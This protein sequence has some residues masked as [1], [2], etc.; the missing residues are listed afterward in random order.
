MSL[1]F[2]LHTFAQAQDIRLFHIERNKNNSIVCYDLHVDDN[3]EINQQNPIDAYW[4]TPDK[5][6]SR[7]SLSLV[8][9]KLAYGLTI[10]KIEGDDISFKLKAYPERDIRV[11]YDSENRQANAYTYI[12]GAF[13]VLKKLYIHAS[14]PLY[15]SVEYIILEGY[16][17]ETGKEVSEMIINT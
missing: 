10:D 9:Y 16:D 12:N 6:N 5:D 15:K 17:P 11:I 8:Q 1:F 3:K 2:L 4:I 14:P 7:N 13:A